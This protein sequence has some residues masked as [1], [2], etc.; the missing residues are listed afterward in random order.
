MIHNLKKCGIPSR[1][2]KYV[3]NLLDCWLTQLK[4]DDYLSQ[5]I[6]IGQGDPLL[7]IFYIIYNADLIEIAEGNKEESLGYV[8][9][10]IV[11]AEGRDFYETMSKLEDIMNQHGGAFDW[12]VQHN[13]NFKINKLAIMH[14]AQ[15]C[16]KNKRMVRLP[17]L[18]LILHGTEINK[19][20]FYKY[21]GIHVDCELQ[22]VLD[23][24]S[25][26]TL[27]E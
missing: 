11:I 16:Q 18:K 26:K 20:E 10:A 19:V 27:L 1:H 9:D 4:F 13:S 3:T 15:K 12:S 14:T 8:D 25:D 17:R 22:W 21:L 23:C 2:I 6:T 7:M 5:P 24:N